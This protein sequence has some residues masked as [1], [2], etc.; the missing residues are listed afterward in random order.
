M[1]DERS[2]ARNQE[3]AGQRLVELV[4]KALAPPPA[5]RRGTRPTRAARQERLDQKAH[6]SRV[7]RTRR[8]ESH[9]DEA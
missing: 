7:K 3:I 8:P 1:Q 5:E 9:D 2:L 4:A 6:R